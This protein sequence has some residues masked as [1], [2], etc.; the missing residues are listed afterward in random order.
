MYNVR[1]FVLFCWLLRAQQKTNPKKKNGPE[2]I[3]N[4]P[5]GVVV[6]PQVG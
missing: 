5:R 1:P 4:P 3:R 6:A 2:K